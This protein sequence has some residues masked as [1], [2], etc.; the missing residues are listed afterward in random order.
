MNPVAKHGTSQHQRSGGD[1]NL[2]FERDGFLT[3]NHWQA[4][5]IPGLSAA[6]H[7]HDIGITGGNDLFTSLT[8]TAAGFADDVER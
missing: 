2:S 7:I 5:S 4:S 8:T 1:S 6:F 3:A